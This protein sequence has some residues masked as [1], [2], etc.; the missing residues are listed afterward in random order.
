ML[1]Q[2]H[3]TF[4][5]MLNHLNLHE[6]LFAQQHVPLLLII[7]TTP[8]G[9]HNPRNYSITLYFTHEHNDIAVNLKQCL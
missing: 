5:F 2:S 6:Q 9:L 8:S 3:C 1:L 4:L 7:H